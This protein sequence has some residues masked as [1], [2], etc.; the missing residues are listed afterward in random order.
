MDFCEPL[1]ELIQHRVSTE[2]RRLLFSRAD[3]IIDSSYVPFLFERLFST[4]LTTRDDIRSLRMP[5]T[6]DRLALPPERTAHSPVQD[7]RNQLRSPM[8]VNT[9]TEPSAAMSTTQPLLYLPLKAM[10]NTFDIDP[11]PFHGRAQ[12]WIVFA[13]WDEDGVIDDH[14]KYALREYRKCAAR[15]TLVSTAC[16]NLPRDLEGV[17]DSF[18]VRDNQGYDFASWQHALRAESLPEWCKQVVFVNSSVYGPVLEVDRCFSRH[19]IAGAHL[20]GMSLSTESERHLQSY[21][22]VMART[23]LES[24]AG[25]Q[26][27]D[28]IKPY[29]H[30]RQVIDAYE[31]RL[32]RHVQQSGFTVRALFDGTHS[33]GIRLKEKI[34]NLLRGPQ[35]RRRLYCRSC[36]AS[37]HNPSHMYWREMLNARVPYVKVELLRDN[38]FGLDTTRVLEYLEHRT[39]YPVE[40]IRNHLRRVSEKPQ[41]N[42]VSRCYRRHAER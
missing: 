41:R 12:R 5:L 23:L 2:E 11:E 17:V 34:R 13:H 3:K 28:A 15:V 21:F 33:R 25:H 4:L 42:R 18:Y 20:W 14:V 16:T 32:L 22:M 35:S 40:L 29:E 1:Y 8:H 7:V 27:W 30:Q 37:T 38:P 10:T 19:E 26:L 39:N 6:K 24:T 36:R 31:V 9:T